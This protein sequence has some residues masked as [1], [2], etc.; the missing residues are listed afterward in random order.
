MPAI[1]S[2]SVDWS[3]QGEVLGVNSSVQAL[4]QALPPV[5]SGIIAATFSSDTPI[6]VAVS[7]MLVSSF[8]FLLFYKPSPE[9]NTSKA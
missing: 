2:K 9:N 4:A 1:V 3:I 6:L 5:L 8:I 7:V